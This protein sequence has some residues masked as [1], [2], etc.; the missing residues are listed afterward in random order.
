MVSFSYFIIQLIS[1]GITGQQYQY[2]FMQNISIF[3]SL[4]TLVYKKLLTADMN[5]EDSVGKVLDLIDSDSDTVG[6]ANM[7]VVMLTGVPVH[8]I[9]ALWM[10]YTQVGWAAFLFLGFVLIRHLCCP[11]LE[12][13]LKNTKESI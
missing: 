2:L 10:L 9:I 8:L 5:P 7:I 12:V 4:K 6:S 1:A 11:R 3:Q 13:P